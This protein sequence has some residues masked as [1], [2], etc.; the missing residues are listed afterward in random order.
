[1]PTKVN[2]RTGTL[3]AP[4]TIGHH[5]VVLKRFKAFFEYKKWGNGTFAV[6]DKKFGQMMEQ[7]MLVCKGYSANTVPATFSVLKVW[8]NAAEEE[9]LIPDRSFHSLKSKGTSVDNIYL[10]DDELRAMYNINFTP[11]F[12]AANKIDPKSRIEDSRDIFIVA[13]HTGLRL[14]DMHKLNQADWFVDA[15]TPYVRVHTTKTGQ[16]VSVPLTKTVIEIYKKYNGHF[17][18]PVDKSKFNKHLQTVGKLAGIT[19]TV[20]KK[21]NKGGHT[22]I[23]EKK[24]YQL[25]GSHTARRSFATN[26]YKASKDARMVM[27]FTGHQ[28]EESFRRYI[29]I[30][31]EEMVDLAAKF[32]VD[33]H[34]VALSVPRQKAIDERK[35]N[36]KKRK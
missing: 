24:K 32:F 29:C 1:M 22:Q 23:E 26:L 5:K 31:D 20:H 14:S 10:N 9:G 30:D 8:L 28:T 19:Q 18:K 3:I 2:P 11:E 6:F 4:R 17:P 27:K 33:R 21:T 13:A 16:T 25:I 15:E 12:M 35:I 34:E 7:W 36:R